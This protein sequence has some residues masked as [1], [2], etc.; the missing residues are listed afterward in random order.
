MLLR[1][2]IAA[3][4]VGALNAAL[5]F[6]LPNVVLAQSPTLLRPPS[7]PLVAHDPYF[8][9]WSSSDK[10]TDSDTRHWTGRP[11]TLSALVRIDGEAFRLMGSEPT[12]VPA[13]PQTRVQV[14]PTR[15]IYEFANQKIAVSLTFTT[16]ALPDDLPVLSRPITYVTFAAHS[17]NG[18]AHSVQW[19]SDAGAE[20]TVNQ[21][22]Q[23]VV[24]SQVAAQGLTTLRMGS[25]EQT[26]LAKR[27]DDLRIDWGYLYLS[28][29]D[30]KGM[31]GVLAP[32]VVS[33]YEWM[34]TGTLPKSDDVRQ[35]RPP[36]DAKPVAALGFD[37]GRVTAAPVTRFLMLGYDDEKSLTYMGHSLEAYWRKGGMQMPRLLSLARDQYEGLQKRCAVF[38]TELITDLRHV[39]GEKY[40]QVAALAYRQSLAANKIVADDNGAPLMFSKENFSNGCIATVDVLYPAAPQLLLFSPTLTKASLVTILSYAASPRW[41]FPFAPH[42]LGTY[43]RADGQ[44]YGGGERTEE[45]QMPVEESGN[46][47]ILLAAVARQ[48]GNARFCEPYWSTI[49]KW[50]GYLEAKG[51]DPERQLSTDDFAGHLAHNVNLSAKAIEALGAYAILCGL[52]GDKAEAMRVH[53]A[54]QAM[55]TRW[56]NEANNGDHYR[57]AFDRPDTWSQ[58]YNLV[59][60]KVLHLN[61]FPESVMQTETAFYRKNINRYGLPLDNREAYTKLDWTIW[62]ATLSGSRADFETITAPIFDFLNTTTDRNPMSDWYQTKEP[63]QVGFQARSVVGGVFLPLLTDTAIWKKWAGRDTLNTAKRPLVWAALPE[64]PVITSVVPTSEKEGIVWRY[65]FD[66]PPSDWTRL[67]FDDGQWKQGPGAFGVA[68]T[69]GAMV[70]TVWNTGDI[71]IRRTLTMPQ[72]T[73]PADLTLIVAHDEDAEIYINGVLAQRLNGFNTGYETYAIRKEAQAKLT[74]GSQITFAVHCHQTTGG[75]GIDIGIVTTTPAA[76]KQSRR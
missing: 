26:V 57:L 60:D 66:A 54:A 12:T 32:R 46:M 45:N 1:R 62:T 30:A 13:L 73:K 20:I 18:V 2:R 43:P 7:V 61:L 4:P 16:P 68:G 44:V 76:P 6:A 34:R 38:D 36:S 35:P 17:R 64:P 22:S 39:G 42:D 24:W 14:L 8:S 52:R 28:A 11:Q 49:K 40:A 56:V 29:P 23:S 19:Y 10:L 48:D 27:G 71:W 63:R 51:F 15:T 74:P 3:T 72:G 70:R 5:F 33:Q 69:S 37:L 59:W 21:P 50:A 67:G 25:Q 41:K 31:Q 53:S 47:L 58:K 55:A 75:Q 9:L 65:R